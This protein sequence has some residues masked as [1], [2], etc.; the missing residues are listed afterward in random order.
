MIC[1]W[2]LDSNAL[3][4]EQGMKDQALLSPDTLLATSLGSDTD[5]LPQRRVDIDLTPVSLVLSTP[6]MCYPNS[7]L[8]FQL[9][10]GGSRRSHNGGGDVAGQK[11]KG[12]VV[13][14]VQPNIQDELKR[15]VQVSLFG[16]NDK[17]LCLHANPRYITLVTASL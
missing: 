7:P 17:D 15:D 8:E 5:P 6:L 10:T 13:A 11:F 12:D 4:F 16:S 14:A 1:D 9:L 3:C 2:Q